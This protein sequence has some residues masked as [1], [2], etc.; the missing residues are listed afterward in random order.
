METNF[1]PSKKQ[2]FSP[3]ELVMLNSDFDYVVSTANKGGQFC[4]RPNMIGMF[5][6]YSETNLIH[7]IAI[8]LFEDVS[9]AIVA[10]R[11][12]AYNS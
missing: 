4:I 6:G 11:L 7:A 9:L 5:L 2:G 8:V 1:K 10:D 3:G 12:K